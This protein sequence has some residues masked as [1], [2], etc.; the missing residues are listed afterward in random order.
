MVTCPHCGKKLKVGK[1]LLASKVKCP[2]CEGV[3]DVKEVLR[4]GH[5]SSSPASNPNP[6]VQRKR[7]PHCG[8]TVTSSTCGM[9]GREND[10][11]DK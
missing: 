11:F 1:N 8:E 10:L 9:C 7:C 6:T 3:I 4:S 2:S 5:G